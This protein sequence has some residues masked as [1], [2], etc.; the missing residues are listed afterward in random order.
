MA[1]EA[2]AGCFGPEFTVPVERGH[3]RQFAHA[4]WANPDA[5]IHGS[6]PII[7]PT[8]PVCAGV[9]WGYTL[10][11]PRGT[12]LE[13][14]DHDLSVPLHAEEAYQFHG[15]LPRIG[16]ELRAR[17]RLESITARQGSRGGELTFLTT[18]TE[19]RDTQD[20]LIIDAR[21]TTVTTSTSPGGDSWAADV[22]DYTPDYTDFEERDPF[23]G[24]QRADRDSLEVGSPPT[25]R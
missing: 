16:D 22:P 15:E 1:N 7:P 4:A 14:I 24:L 18:H 13:D 2:I 23:A 8:W 25:V 20:A 3:V 9:L 17:C 6:K 12:L 19:F 10:E 21:A 5:H 11:R